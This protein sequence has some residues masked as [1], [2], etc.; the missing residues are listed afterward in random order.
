MKVAPVDYFE[1]NN[2]TRR[3][4]IVGQAFRFPATNRRDFWQD[5]L[6]GKDFVT[7]VSPD[8]WSTS[9]LQHP[10]KTHPGTAYTFRAGSLGDVSGF[11]AA[12]FGISPR[13]AAQM[14]PQQRLL[15]EMA[16]ET[17]EDAGIRASH[18]RGSQCGVFIGL[19]GTDYGY[20]AADDLASIE[21]STATGTTASLAANRLSYF[22]DW[23]GPSMVI[24]TACSSALVAFHQACKAIAS[25]EVD[26]AIAGSINLH[27]HP[28]GFIIFSK[29][30]M[31][32][33]RGRSRAFDASGDGYVRSE[34]GGLFLLKDYDQAIADGNNILAVVSHTAVNTDGRKTGVTVPNA[35]AQAALLQTAYAAAGI[36]PAQIDYVEAHGTGTAVGD[37]LET[38]ALG[39]ALGSKRS[40][41]EPLPI[42]SVKSNLGHLESASG[43][44]GL[45]KALYALKHRLVPAT[46]GVDT[47]NP[48]IHLDEWK[49][50]VV[51][52]NRPLKPA[53][54]LT[55]GINS[56]GFGGSNAHVILQS[57]D[58]NVVVG[59]QHTAQS[60]PRCGLPLIISA[61]SDAA[62]RANAL[63]ASRLLEQEDCD[64][65][66]LAWHAL[67]RRDP[68]E[69]RAVLFARDRQQAA[70]ALAEFAEGLTETGVSAGEMLPETSGPAFIYSGNG[71]QW[72]GMGKALLEDPV[73]RGAVQE[74]DK[75]FA[76]LAG[77]RLEDELRRGPDDE[78]LA[79]TEIAQPCL[80][81]YQLGV[82]EM[83]RAH[84][85]RPRAVSGHSVGEVAA[86]WACGALPLELAVRVI[87]QRSRLQG[88]TRGQGQMSAIGLAAETVQTL[89]TEL[90][91]DKVCIAGINSG[92]GVTVA[93]DTAELATLENRLQSD[94]TFCKRLALDYAF[95]SPAM[96]SIE[97]DILD[98][99]QDLAPQACT[100][101]YFSTVTGGLLAG[102]M[103]DARYWWDNIRQPVAFASA[104]KAIVADGI[105][106]FVEVG[107]HPVLRGYL[108]EALKDAG[109]T[110]SVIPT[111]RRKDSGPERILAACAAHFIAGGATDW[112]AYFP[113]V[114]RFIE[115][116]HYAWQ[117]E[118]FWRP[119]TSESLGQ[120]GGELR[121]PLL[122]HAQAQQANQWENVLDPRV[123]PMLADHVVGDAVVF[124]GAAY[125]ELALA[126]A[127][128]TLPA[129]PIE[130]ESL[131]IRAPLLFAQGR[132]QKLR[133]A[134]DA[135]DGGLS[136]QARE[137]AGDADWAV[138][139][140]ARV[141]A[142]PGS[143]L[144]ER[145][146]WAGE[147]DREPDFDRASHLALNEALGLNYGPGFQAI[148]R[149]WLDTDEAFARLTVPAT[150]A[151]S[152]PDY[153]LHPGI[154]DSCFQ[155]VAQLLRQQGL[156]A[157]GLAFIP[158]RIGRIAQQTLD[159]APRFAHARLLRRSPHSLLAE[160][161]VFDPQ[162]RAIAVL[163]EVRFRAVR[164]FR[165][166]TEQ[167]QQLHSA[168]HAAPQ[169]RARSL[170]ER[171]EAASRLQGTSLHTFPSQYDDE[172]SPLLD[173]LQLAYL[174]E[175]QA[176][177][178]PLRREDSRAWH[179]Q[180]RDADDPRGIVFATL[181]AEL[182][183]NDLTSPQPQPA[184]DDETV[185]AA[186]DIWLMLLREY[187][188]YFPLFH[189]VS[190]VAKQVRSVLA[191]E[192]Q[193]LPTLPAGID[194]GSLSQAILRGDK[195]TQIANTLGALVRST[196]QRLPPGERLRILEVGN[197]VRFAS[198][199]GSELSPVNAD[200]CVASAQPE[201]AAQVAEL[202]TQHPALRF[203]LIAS[204]THEMP[205]Q[206]YDI[207]ILC[208]GGVS[209]AAADEL[210]AHARRQLLPGAPLLLISNQ[211]EEWLRSTLALAGLAAPD[212]FEALQQRVGRA[213]FE[214]IECLSP[215]PGE[216]SSLC[217]LLAHAP[218][219]PTPS[220]VLQHWLLLSEPTGHVADL[221]SAL[222]GQLAEQGHTASIC[223]A[224][225]E[226]AL[227]AALRELPQDNG[228]IVMLRG[229][230]PQ[231]E[232]AAAQRCVS[233]AEIARV[234]ESE[235]ITAPLLIVTQQALNDVLPNDA[236]SPNAG[237]DAALWGFGRTLANETSQA[238]RL[239][240]LHASD[241]RKAAEQLANA[242][243]AN[244]QETEC[245]LGP[246]GGRYATRI[247]PARTRVESDTW[248]LGLSLPGQLRNLSWQAATLPLPGD[249]E[250]LVQVHATGLNF[251]DVM[252]ALGLLSDEALENGFAG[253]TLGLEFAGTVLQVGPEV[254]GF[255]RGDRVVG[256]G[257]ACF[258]NRLITRDSTIAVIP[259]GMSF[260]AAAT[261]PTTFLT[262]Y[263]A[264]HH[265]A[266][267]EPGERVLIHGGAGGV[268][269]AAI[270]IARWLG[271]TV[272]ATAG[273]DEKREF[274]RLLGV[275]H[276][277][278]SRSLSY[279]DDILKL[280]AGEGVDVVLNSLAGEAI[281][282]NFQVLRPFGRFLELGKRDFYENTRVGLRPFRNNL[283]Y[284]GID[285][286]QL[287]SERPALTR[288][289]FGE[290]MALFADG[291]LHAL[292]WH[293]FEAA[294]VVDAF[295]H[296]QQARQIG[297]IVVTY[298][299]GMRVSPAMSRTTQDERLNL[300][301]SASY[302]V[303]GG[304]S[305]FGL[306][307]AEWLAERGARNLVLISRR[308]PRTEEAV[309]GIARLEAQ[310]VR[311]IAEAC[312]V[313]DL[314]ALRQLLQRPDLPPLRGIV[315]A[316]AVI[317]DALIRNLDAAQIDRVLG[318]KIRGA[319]NLHELS[320]TAP[321]DFFV[322]YSS[323]TT[324]FGN[325]GQ[326]AY[327]A[328]NSWLEALARHRRASGLPATSLLW[329]AIDDAGFLA[330]NEKIKEALQSRMGGAPL[331]AAL[332]LNMLEAQLLTDASGLGLLELDW[333]A[334][335]RFL[336]TATTPRF[337]ELSRLHGEAK[338]QDDEG[339]DLQQMLSEL[340]DDTLHA[341]VSD[342]L[343]QEIG[344]ILR[345]APDK[346]AADRPIQE[347][348]LDSLMG[349]ELVTALDQRFGV[350]LPVLALS[351]SPTV[352][353]L[354]T[355]LIEQL[356]EPDEEAPAATNLDRQ[357]E[358]LAAIHA[359][360]T[361]VARM[362][363]LT[364]GL[365]SAAQSEQDVAQ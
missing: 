153:L 87:Y 190:Q 129:G 244:D 40:P 197:D 328:A 311:V 344:E 132:S 120:F 348:G 149:G 200:Y 280:T 156:N 12:F 69:H 17:L 160:F 267:V 33:P 290:V 335:S 85:I 304:L 122:G 144:L 293:A 317:E 111:G 75:H 49:L 300:D 347:L 31:L 223:H 19:A 64:L 232:A 306:R 320:R 142:E 34:G 359:H 52:A 59:A 210:L 207:A 92:T 203:E 63:A 139:A 337:Q 90:G 78:R 175:L 238:V 98:S 357:I 46:I 26:C 266:R 296:M 199:L 286:D 251:R 176:A 119:Q 11:D 321:L 16:W 272:F 77:F 74:I 352:H 65:Y 329:G 248:K 330:R 319:Q 208:L 58:R 151:A 289:L 362:A 177:T 133:V 217:L 187:P 22:F 163:E 355:R 229:L 141:L 183:R 154:L 104:M 287:M 349:V 61:R 114:G 180:S 168:L 140:T 127:R 336:P 158:T 256:F 99:L 259:T 89:L 212:E 110:G 351:E 107:P 194:A 309:A 155:I 152:L 353:R 273:S 106:E 204:G 157:N 318:P 112:S 303:T 265:L 268:G 167:I 143:R 241:P 242:I 322:L 134:L 62:L 221:A 37:P 338:H 76:P 136:I 91:L 269:I 234:C 228:G 332:A 245:V 102:Q 361:P 67:H 274:L 148:E 182:E 15:L 189:S 294:Q 334:L 363:D 72:A 118:R 115:F 246:D 116:P 253:A 340:D 42:G 108:S 172:L 43:V 50:D 18:M 27:L 220:H 216:Q 1:K 230:N 28:Y 47:I 60:A 339:D 173:A 312:D 35:K 260:E 327:V 226:S 240:D 8:R 345:I 113:V 178:E 333:H 6:D 325:P 188:D 71:S 21:A 233:A 174:R 360:D 29:A 7:S 356:R 215:E 261:I 276:V 196:L 2:T 162:G 97:A 198:R 53:G 55:I 364:Q 314:D 124:P 41:S 10:D 93:G 51:T 5:L 185:V 271:A 105:N 316:A 48:N 297:K 254:A 96:D 66:D 301:A 201:L 3:I 25:G 184:G 206:G 205:A 315:H 342:M 281:N 125:A 298:R 57:H 130:I 170:I 299:D 191:G 264:L 135:A 94:G 257:S 262:A 56:F 32:S 235:Q 237:H 214:D 147:P 275:E 283:T 307:T 128:E 263:Y 192:L 236:P 131:E 14:D 161:S 137:Y 101:P 211:P 186:Q 209:G 252:Y 358:Q 83:L 95:H 213:G 222:Q 219:R 365:D 88:Q 36:H 326:A 324:L 138:H 117:R 30:S 179:E 249:G 308:G 166:Q 39:E 288:R 202:S 38:A 164:L 68:L 323:A 181:A 79:L 13:E 193:R 354:A 310:G 292:P 54:K 255:A 341:T 258:A 145:A 282:R 224:D 44:A 218:A 86:A 313:T 171:S 225:S 73:F 123:L 295:R 285:A 278:D 24:D 9:K 4:A 346:I 305:G 109:I 247:L 103:L 250:V 302:L 126:A 20:R 277:F 195:L 150:I 231:D 80:F 82:T 284:F 165:N 81:A 121:H 45:V 343:R 243:V 350:R 291:T 70:H 227:G 146:T 23:H 84:G 279:A 331:R 159:G 100:I 239:I 270:Q 169:A